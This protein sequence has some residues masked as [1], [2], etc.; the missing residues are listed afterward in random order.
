MSGLAKKTPKRRR[1]KNSEMSQF[2]ADVDTVWLNHE[3]L[4][5]PEELLDLLAAEQL[6]QSSETTLALNNS[7]PLITP[8]E[9]AFHWLATKKPV[10]ASEIVR[11]VI[12]VADEP[13]TVDRL[14][15]LGVACGELRP[16]KALP[17]GVVGIW[18][19]TLPVILMTQEAPTKFNRA[20]EIGRALGRLISR[21]DDWSET[22]AG[23]LRPAFEVFTVHPQNLQS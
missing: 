8:T 12:D 11:S 6:A 5:D 10:P 2:F 14:G 3:S 21:N 15:I 7:G 1:M 17:S 16:N 4:G 18:R 9:Q 23:H 13:T 20:E 22:F 19:S